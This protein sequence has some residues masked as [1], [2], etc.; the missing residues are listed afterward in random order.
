[1]P[2]IAAQ[3]PPDHAITKAAWAL[4]YALAIA[5]LNLLWELLQLPLYTVWAVGSTREIVFDVLHCT[6]GDLLIAGLSLLAAL[7]LV[8]PNG[9]PQQPSIATCLL[10]LLL[11]VGYTVHSEW[12]N[13]TVTHQWA[14]SGLMP[15]IAGIGLSPIAQWLV[16][17]CAAFRWAQR[18]IL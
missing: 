18:P 5:A 1:M 8:Q 15:Q 3:S 14:Y 16:I 6:V 13:T 12:Y 2:S 9:W 4:R 11:G 7:A 17:P 10:T